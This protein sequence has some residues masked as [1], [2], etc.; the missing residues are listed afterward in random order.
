MESTKIRYSLRKHVLQCCD[1]ALDEVG[2]IYNV[3]G[4]IDPELA[5]RSADRYSTVHGGKK[6]TSI[7]IGDMGHTCTL[8]VRWEGGVPLCRL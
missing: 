4:T 3:K 5:D 8:Y 6:F 1:T 7:M 2:T